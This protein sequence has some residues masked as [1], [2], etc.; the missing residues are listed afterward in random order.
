MRRTDII[1]QAKAIREAT[2]RMGRTAPDEVALSCPAMFDEWESG[3][4][5]AL[6]DVRQQDGQLYRCQQA[7]TSQDSWMPSI[8]PALWAAINKTAAGTVDDPIPAV[9]GMEYEYGLYY[10]DP[11]D[12]KTYLC[13]RGEESGTIILQFLPHE[14]VGQYFSEEV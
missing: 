9:R 4:E 7:H 1:E 3:R 10:L 8:T 12:G 2:Q 6:G 11:V 5:Y 14:L 13:K